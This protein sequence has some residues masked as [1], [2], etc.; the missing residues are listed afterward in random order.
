MHGSAHTQKALRRWGA[1]YSISHT[2]TLQQCSILPTIMLQHHV[3]M[4]V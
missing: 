1:H 3:C 2:V 4:S